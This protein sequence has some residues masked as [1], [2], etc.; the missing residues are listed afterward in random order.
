LSEPPED[1]T[2]LAPVKRVIRLELVLED[3]LVSVDIGP[4]RLRNQVSHAVRQQ[5]PVSGDSVGT[6]DSVGRAAVESCR[7]SIGLVTL[8]TRQVTMGWVMSRS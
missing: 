4:K 6:G 2:S 5:G 7:R 3:P 8:V 1:P